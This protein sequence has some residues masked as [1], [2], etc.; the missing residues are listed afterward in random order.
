M[1]HQMECSFTTQKGCATNTPS[2]VRNHVVLR[3]AR[4]PLSNNEQR[5]T[6]CSPISTDTWFLTPAESST[7]DPTGRPGA[8]TPLLVSFKLPHPPPHADQRI[9]RGTRLPQSLRR[10]VKVAFSAPA[11]LRRHL[12]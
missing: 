1:R 9:A 7:C 10:D 4:K 12:A 8:N 5:Q 3:A 2:W 6:M 11:T